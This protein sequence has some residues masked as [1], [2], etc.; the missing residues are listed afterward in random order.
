M[1]RLEPV[2]KPLL[3]EDDLFALQVQPAGSERGHKRQQH[4]CKDRRQRECEATARPGIGCHAYACVS[5]L[6][7]DS[8]RCRPPT[9]TSGT[10]PRRS[11]RECRM[12]SREDSTGPLCER[13]AGGDS[14][15]RRRQRAGGR[16]P[17]NRGHKT[18]EQGRPD[19]RRR[20]Q[21]SHRSL[22]PHA[23]V[24]C[25]AGKSPRRRS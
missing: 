1:R 21:E 10:W 12:R 11:A 5:M 18:E 9:P 13:I 24:S 4:R 3:V 20:W 7:S 6:P 19:A 23:A 8:C 15:R 25:R 16:P 22:G 14:I 17:G 2:E